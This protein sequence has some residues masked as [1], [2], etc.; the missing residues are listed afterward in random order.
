MITLGNDKENVRQ[1]MQEAELSP[2][3][4]GK[5]AE[6]LRRQDVYRQSS[7]LFVGPAPQLSQ[8]RINALLDGKTLMVPA[9]AIKKGFYR[10]KPYVIPFRDLS[11]AVSLKGIEGFG[12][13]LDSSGLA[14]L[15]IDLA[16]TDC[17][18]MGPGGERLGCG[19]GFFDLA[20]GILSELGAV[21]S[22]TLFGA[23][24]VQEQVLDEDLPQES[25]DVRLHFFL[26]SQGLRLFPQDAQKLQVFW[27]ALEKKRIRKIEPLWQLYQARFPGSWG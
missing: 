18:A 9:P 27:G 25:W 21:D 15:H 7:A 4:P 10:L 23:V 6:I 22:E 16:L 8:I 26:A 13:L 20:M 3:H 11:H 14:K 17:L 24:G 19:T 5:I 12:K 2:L 1:K